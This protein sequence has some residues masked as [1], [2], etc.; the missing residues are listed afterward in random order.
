MSYRH[1]TKEH[2]EFEAQWRNTQAGEAFFYEARP[3]PDC[4]LPKENWSWGVIEFITSYDGF[5][6]EN[7]FV[8]RV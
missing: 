6:R 7:G 1:P 3:Y 5:T 4:N 8:W 2:A